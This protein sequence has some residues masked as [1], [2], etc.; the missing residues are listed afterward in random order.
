MVVVPI[1][2]QCQACGRRNLGEAGELLLRVLHLQQ[3]LQCHFPHSAMQPLQ[4]LRE[5]NLIW[6]SA[7]PAQGHARDAR[8]LHLACIAGQQKQG[9]VPAQTTC[10]IGGLRMDKSM[11]LA[12]STP[13][14]LMQLSIRIATYL[15]VLSFNGG[16]RPFVHVKL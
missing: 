4:N 7:S 5:M 6:A 15:N 3:H 10:T 12:E 14:Q 13:A 1:V 8:V 9:N 11:H 16:Q 2:T